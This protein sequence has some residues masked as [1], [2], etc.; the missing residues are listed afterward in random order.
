MNDLVFDPNN[1]ITT[2]HKTHMAIHYG[3]SRSL[4]QPLIVRFPGDTIPWK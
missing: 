2:T 1:L 4:Y 3:D